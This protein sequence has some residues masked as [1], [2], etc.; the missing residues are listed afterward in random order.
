LSAARS[1]GL[2]CLG[3]TGAN[4]GKM[5]AQ[6]DLTLEAPSTRTAVIQQIHITAAHV[7]CAL[8]ERAMFPRA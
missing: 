1:H 4:E 7:V 6:C 5:R 8:V 2:A 3:F